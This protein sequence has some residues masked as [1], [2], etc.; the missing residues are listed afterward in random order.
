MLEASKQKLVH[1]IAYYKESF[2]LFR[3]ISGFIFR[4]HTI[5]YGYHSSLIIFTA[6]KVSS[7]LKSHMTGE[8]D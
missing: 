1:V 8:Y 5:G 2:A 4:G 6:S 7:G 3:K